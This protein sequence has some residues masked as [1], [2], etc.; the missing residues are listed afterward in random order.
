MFDKTE[1]ETRAEW[2]I[3]GGLTQFQA[4]LNA[5]TDDCK[6]QILAQLL[7]AGQAATATSQRRLLVT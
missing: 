6:Y 4:R 1:A 3:A 5:E 7:S 2:I